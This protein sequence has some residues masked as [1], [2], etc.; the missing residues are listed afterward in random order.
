MHH[1]TLA[2]T[3]L[4]FATL[5]PINPARRDPSGAPH[6]LSVFFQSP[7]KL[8]SPA[9][10]ATALLSPTYSSIIKLINSSINGIDKL[11]GQLHTIKPF[12]TGLPMKRIIAKWRYFLEKVGFGECISFQMLH[13]SS[14]SLLKLKCSRNSFSYTFCSLVQG[15]PSF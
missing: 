4:Q 13:F 12:S 2:Q 1:L 3:E 10:L 14:E 7:P 11:L 6:S 15:I 5:L 9:N 8:L